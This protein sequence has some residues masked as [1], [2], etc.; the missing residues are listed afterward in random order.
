MRW[1]A[2]IE[3][4]SVCHEPVTT[5]DFFPTFLDAAGLPL[6][7]SEH[8]D[9]VSLLPL[10]RQEGDLTR[11]AIFWHYPHY[12]NQGGTPGCA[13]RSGDWKLIEFFEDSRLELYN[14]RQDAGE[15]NNLAGQRPEMVSSLHSLLRNWRLDLGARIPGPNPDWN[16]LPNPRLHEG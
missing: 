16:S 4:G 5:T 10:M 3:P 8:C 11:E 14:L 9:G 1:P 12:S 2:Q 13:V 6:R 7:P 15:E